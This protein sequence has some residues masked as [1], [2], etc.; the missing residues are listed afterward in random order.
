MASLKVYIS[1]AMTG[2][3]EWNYPAFHARATDL[4]QK[5]Y[6]V[7]NPAENFDGQKDLPRWMY[8]REDIKNLLSS[9]CIAF[10]PGFEKSAG[11]LLEALVARE[12]NIPTLEETEQ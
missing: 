9:D 1:G 12:C 5:G 8:L 6:I 10:L 4:R 3:P 7:L 2:L 11:A